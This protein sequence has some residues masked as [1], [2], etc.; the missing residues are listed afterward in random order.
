[1]AKLIKADLARMVKTR[2]FWICG[3]SAVGFMLLNFLLDCGVNENAAKQM[4]L[5]MFG[6]SSNLMLFAAI[7][8]GLYIGTD[9]SNGT[10]RNKISVGHGRCS[11][12]L[13]NL[14]VSS[15]ASVIYTLAGWAVML[16]ASLFYGGALGVEAGEFALKLAICLLSMISACSLFTFAGM[17]ISIKSSAVVVIIV[18]A[19]VLLVGAAGL[20]SWLDMPEFTS[21][22]V[23]TVDGAVAP[24]DPEP[25]PLYLRGG[26]R[27]FIQAVCD[28]LP[29]GQAMQLELAEPHLPEL[30]PLYSIGVTAAA[31]AIGAAA[32]AKKDLK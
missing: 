9:Y 3:G 1:M 18:G 30:M 29:S 13:S 32:F 28:I 21:G 12:Y 23:L 17:L 6:D 19:F 24:M 14:I 16:I 26:M 11:I 8:A 15:A 5:V 10:I 27:V 22:Y 2:S 31:T 7:F 25:N 4:G 20:L